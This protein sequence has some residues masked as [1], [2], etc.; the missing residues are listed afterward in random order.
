AALRR[1]TA[2]GLEDAAA[3]AGLAVTAMRTFAEWDAHEQGQAVQ[4]EPLIAISRIGDAPAEPLSHADRP[5][6]GLRVLDLTRVIAGPVCGRTLAVHGADVL[7][8]TGPRIFNPRPLVIDGGRG[9][10]SARLD[11][12]HQSGRETLRGLLSGADIFVQGYRPGAIADL[13]FGPEEAARIRPGIVYVSLCAYG[14]TGP[15]AGRRGFDSLTQTAS[16]FNAAEGEAAGEPGRPKP[17]PMQAL[18]HSSGYLMALGALA[19]LYRR[20][21]I[22][23]SWHVCVSLARTGHWIRGLGR[24]PG[25]LACRQPT[26]AEIADLLE[27]TDSGFGRLSDVRH[28]GMLSVTP[29]YWQRPSVPPGTHPAEWP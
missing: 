6:A 26:R 20:S 15:W 8:I 1:W 5:L 18:D 19:G 29:P 11:L 24:V 12:K 4:A 17:L 27:Q 2:F 10:L 7:L 9:K 21:R 3:E 13:G 23:G 14:H 16:G 22:G 28:A 25:G